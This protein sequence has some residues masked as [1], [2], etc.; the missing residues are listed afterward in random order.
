MKCRDPLSHAA[1][2]GSAGALALA[3]GLDLRAAEPDPR[4]RILIAGDSTASFYGP[5]RFPRMGWGQ[6]L[7]RYFDKARVEVVNRA[8]SGRSTKSY[9][10]E[11]RLDTLARELRAG[12][13]LLIQFGHNDEKREDPNRYTDSA[14][15]F[16]RLLT[17]FVEAARAAGATP[18]LVTPVQRLSWSNGDIADTHGGYDDAVR[19]LAQRE[20]VALIDL[21]ELSRDWLRALGEPA[22]H[23]YYLY[24]PEQGLADDTH[25]QERG[26]VM[27]ACLVARGMAE[28]KLAPAQA[29]VRDTDCGVTPAFL[30]ARAAQPHPSLIQREKDIPA[31]QPGPH[32]GNSPTTAFPF[33]RDAPGLGFAFRKRILHRGASIG[34]H[35]HDHDEVY[36]VI[37]GRGEIVLDGVVHPVETGTAILTR[38]GSS[39]AL[40]QK[41]DEDLV[42]L[43][44]YPTPPPPAP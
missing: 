15:E 1:I 31:I 30:Q 42:I 40:H 6:V 27:V 5:E 13:V 28:N 19:A 17:R 26:A 41:G 8:Q 43:I 4:T 10:A 22:S 16:P 9:I 35:P 34:L 37:A 44:T 23:G 3:I 25:F 29:L 33:F 7:D 39:H 20:R 12:D 18:V 24:V 38:T 14:T 36:Y 11:G 2:L 21:A 32:G